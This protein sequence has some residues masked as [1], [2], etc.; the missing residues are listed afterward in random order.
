M[1]R[2]SCSELFIGYISFLSKSDGEIS[3]LPEIKRTATGIISN[4]RP[5][6]GVS[7]PTSGASTQGI[8]EGNPRLTLL[9]IAK[10]DAART[11]LYAKFLRGPILGPDADDVVLALPEKSLTGE[12]EDGQTNHQYAKLNDKRTSGVNEDVEISTSKKRHPEDVIARTQR[13][14]EKKEQKA[15]EKEERR[16]LRRER[17]TNGEVSSGATSEE[18]TE[19]GNKKRHKLE[20]REKKKSEG[21]YADQILEGT[22]KQ[23]KKS[24]KVDLG[25]ADVP[26]KETNL[27]HREILKSTG[28]L[29]PD[30]AELASTDEQPSHG[31]Y[32]RKKKKRKRD[33]T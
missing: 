10:R 11:S 9:S 20:S 13:K 6:T 7:V 17:R 1:T 22:E 4:R 28:I 24:R 21:H 15:K 29:D 32:E 18:T 23:K 31:V 3:S 5:M 30:F 16:A 33:E 2:Y 26:R 8:S 27:K 14:K 25:T 12:I 19:K